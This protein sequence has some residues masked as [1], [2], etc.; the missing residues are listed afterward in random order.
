MVSFNMFKGGIYLDTQIYLDKIVA[1]FKEEL[2]ENLLG[3]YLHGSLSM[4]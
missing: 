3:I 2:K 1:C 4:G